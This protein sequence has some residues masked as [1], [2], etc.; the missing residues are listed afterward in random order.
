MTV[1][2][3]PNAGDPPAAQRFFGIVELVMD[4]LDQPAISAVQVLQA[5]RV[6]KLFHTTIKNTIALRRKALRAASRP[7]GEPYLG[8]L[9]LNTTMIPENV[10]IEPFANYFSNKVRATLRSDASLIFEMHFATQEL[11][12]GSSPLGVITDNLK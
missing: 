8:A 7:N 5:T 4:C 10:D 11:F 6:N 3:K 9:I 12:N 2:I 1:S